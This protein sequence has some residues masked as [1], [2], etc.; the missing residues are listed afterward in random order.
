MVIGQQMKKRGIIKIIAGFCPSVF[1][2]LLCKV[3]IIEVIW[4]KNKVFWNVSVICTSLF[5]GGTFVSDV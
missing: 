4:S 3:Q 2:R 5:E 1:I